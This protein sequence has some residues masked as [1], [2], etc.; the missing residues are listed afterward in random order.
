MSKLQ[1]S[2]RGQP[3][4]KGKNIWPQSVLYSEVPLTFAC[5]LSQFLWQKTKKKKLDAED[6]LQSKVEEL[7]SLRRVIASF[8]I[9]LINAANIL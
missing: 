7:E 1:I 8:R 9:Y 4:Y 5:M 6:E 3:P 2:E